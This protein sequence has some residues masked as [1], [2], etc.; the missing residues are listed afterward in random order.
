MNFNLSQ[1]CVILCW[2]L[3]VLF[4]TVAMVFISVAVIGSHD[5]QQYAKISYKFCSCLEVMVYEI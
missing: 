5:L 1:E 4:L 3:F 2:L